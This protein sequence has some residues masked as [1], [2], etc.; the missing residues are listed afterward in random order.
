MAHGAPATLVSR[1]ADRM[2]ALNSVIE[3]DRTL[4]RQF[5]VGHS[6]FTP[7]HSPGDDAGAWESWY[8]ETVRT[9]VA[10]LLEEYWFDDEEKAKTQTAR[11]LAV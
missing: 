10:P 7:T 9:E 3:G 2:G 1:I 8:R 6:F 5:K 4:G 11:L